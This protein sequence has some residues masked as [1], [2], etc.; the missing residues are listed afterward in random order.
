MSD[1]IKKYYYGSPVLLAFLMFGSN[2]LNTKMFSFGDLNFTV[3]FVLSVFS[4]ACGWLI[5]K[6][7]N[8]RRGGKV[9]FALIVATTIV[10][11][12]MISLF[13]EY[14]A[15]NELLAEN[16]IL[17][18]LRNVVLGCM[19]FFG[20]SVAEV[21]HLQKEIL[22]QN[23]K[24]ESYEN[25]INIAQKE[26]ELKI[27]EAKLNAQGIVREAELQA[28]SYLEKKERMEKELKEIIQIERELIRKYEEN[29]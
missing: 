15:S 27:K 26:A 16:L 1:E 8:W 12:V 28:R 3:W 20:M 29:Q 24:I 14:F 10:S 17:Y 21:F 5:N 4:F 7:L 22:S 25:M 9:V 11:V 19:G 13:R 23:N 6:T 2:F 18:S